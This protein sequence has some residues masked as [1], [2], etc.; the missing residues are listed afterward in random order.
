[1]TGQKQSRA[2]LQDKKIE[3]LTKVLQQLLDENTYL[4]DLAV[5]TLQTVKKL[6]GYDKA[7]EELKQQLVKEP[8]E[9]KEADTGRKIIE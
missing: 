9:A 2:D 1:M 8:G 4:K 6:P 7:I 5:G 3:A